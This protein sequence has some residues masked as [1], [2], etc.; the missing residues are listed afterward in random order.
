MFTQPKGETYF[1][2]CFGHAICQQVLFTLTR[3]GRLKHW[4]CTSLTLKKKNNN[5]NNNNTCMKTVCTFLSFPQLPSKKNDQAGYLHT[6]SNILSGSRKNASGWF[7]KALSRT[8]KINRKHHKNWA[9]KHNW[10]E[11]SGGVLVCFYLMIWCFSD[12][13][14]LLV[15]FSLCLM[16]TL[17]VLFRIS[18]AVSFVYS[19]L[20]TM[21]QNGTVKWWDSYGIA[22]SCFLL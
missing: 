5:S 11:K 19:W 17:R 9:V 3:P 22:I 13:F 20:C 21:P 2:H 12:A 4:D 18:C 15:F 16:R 7:S 6:S 1:T 8:S 10:K 14:T